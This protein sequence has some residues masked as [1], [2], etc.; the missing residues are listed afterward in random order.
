[1]T[2]ERNTDPQ[3]SNPANIRKAEPDEVAY[4]DG[5]VQGRASERNLQST[6]RQLEYTNQR[7]REDNQA[8]SGVV[9]GLVLASIVGAI[10]GI[11]YFLSQNP[12][13]APAPEATQAQPVA[14]E[15]P[16][17]ERQT[18]VIERTV[19][20]VREVE[21]PAV[22]EVEVNIP[23]PQLPAVEP[24]QPQPEAVQP[25]PTEAPAE[26]PASEAPPQ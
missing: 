6:N 24:V 15:P 1:M 17:I 10:A 5:Y 7:V 11:L 9:V 2:R 19:D 12:A 21:P 25:N 13:V 22:P 18:T 23:S 8:V 3:A 26:A 20:R 14:P 16:V 4:R